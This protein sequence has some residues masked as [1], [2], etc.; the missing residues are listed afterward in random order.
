MFPL[1][2]P[3]LQLT[4][5]VVPWA[6]TVMTGAAKT[7][8]TNLGTPFDVWPRKLVAHTRSESAEGV[9]VGE[10][11]L[12]LAGGRAPPAG[13]AGGG[14]G[15]HGQRVREHPTLLAAAKDAHHALT[16]RRSQIARGKCDK[17]H[18][19]LRYSGHHT[20]GS[21]N[22]CRNSSWSWRSRSGGEEGLETGGVPLSGAP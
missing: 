19:R 20:R 17:G 11:S 18:Q 22:S 8:H 7:D 14:R 6:N 2:V 16:T 12:G 4:G 15:V 1:P 5:D 9:G 10:E 3:P 21:S 13:G